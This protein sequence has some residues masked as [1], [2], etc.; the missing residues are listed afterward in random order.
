M[1]FE[2]RDL[3]IANFN[4]MSYG[5]DRK[6]PIFY[7]RIISFVNKLKGQKWTLSKIL[8]NIIK[9]VKHF[10]KNVCKKVKL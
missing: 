9:K 1:K 10:E 2:L 8:T 5:D 6:Q 7:Q 4:I 3:K